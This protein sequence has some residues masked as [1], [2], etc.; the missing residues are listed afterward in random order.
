MLRNRQRPVWSPDDLARIYAGPHDHRVLGDGHKA[1][2]DGLID[3][4]RRLWPNPTFVADLSCGNGVIAEGLGARR[5]TLGDY[6]PG[7]QY[8]GPIEETIE[9]IHPVDVFVCAE[10][11]EH[12][13]DPDT[14][15]R[16]I[17]VKANALVC[18]VPISQVPADDQNGEHY[19][20][21]DRAG[22]E[23]MLMEA[24]WEPVLYEQVEAGPGS[25]N[26]TYQ[27]GLWGCTRLDPWTDYGVTRNWTQ[28]DPTTGEP[29]D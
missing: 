27:C 18:S 13:D 10:T 24:G 25:V 26:P 7:F 14:V 5:T 12:L 8:Q 23:R 15:L 20:A 6:A 28:I 2:V 1:R 29:W 22:A 3:I 11:I 19:W 4:G 21:F 16:R 17:R 9:K